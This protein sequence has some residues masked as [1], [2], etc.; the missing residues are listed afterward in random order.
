MSRALRVARSL[1]TA[2]ARPARYPCSR[3]ELKPPCARHYSQPTQQT[4]SGERDRSAVGV[5]TPK[6]A[7]LFVAT[8]VGLYLYFR[9]EKQSCRSKTERARRQAGR[10]AARRRSLHPHDTYE[11]TLH[12][13]RLLGSWSLIYFGF[14]N[15]PDIC[16]EEL[17]KMS[18]AV[19]ELDK[20]FGPVVQP[21]FIS[22]DPARDTIPQVARYV[23]DF[24]PRLVGLTGDYAA[25]KATC[26]AYRVYFSTP[27]D[28]KADDD[29][30]VDH[31][32][33]FYFMDPDGKFVDA[34]GKASSVEDVVARVQ[35][36]IAL[37]KERRGRRRSVPPYL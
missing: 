33:F 14:T 35:K 22:V 16:P 3:L 7:A 37:W 25:T 12:R 8:G 19:T 31:S 5:F 18:A 4:S 17:D 32:I 11:H 24:H 21:V 1:R 10:T 30:L 28:A 34:F 2:A 29:Y 36:E 9:Y 23:A 20:Q 27:P 26:K 6:A 13:K 15:C